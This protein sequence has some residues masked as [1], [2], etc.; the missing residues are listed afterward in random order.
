MKIFSPAKINLFLIVTGRRTDGYHDIVSLMCGI[1]LYDTIFLDVGGSCTTISCAHPDVPEDETNLVFKAV[2]VFQKA[3]DRYDGVKITIEKKIPVA[4]GLGGGSSNAAAVLSGLNQFHGY[5]FSKDDLMAMGLPIGADVPF[6]L[7]NQPA[8]A[9]GIGEK[10]T[11]CPGLQNLNVLLVFPGFGV[12]TSQIYKSLNL[13]LTNCKK[14]LKQVLLNHLNFDPRYHL[15][16]DLETI[17]ASRYPV[18]SAAKNTLLD[19]GA[20]GALMSGSGPTVL[21]L[22]SDF[23]RAKAASLTL[24]R[25]SKWRIYLADMLV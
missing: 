22:F 21:G 6:F 18:I 1:S 2:D 5:P 4:A 11:G 16:N 25:N 10:L 23:D 17:V 7:Y 20:I 9:S 19:L 3:S 13:R 12:A 24:S 15:C 8:I 14:K